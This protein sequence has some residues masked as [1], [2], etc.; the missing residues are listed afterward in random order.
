MKNIFHTLF[1]TL[2]LLGVTSC[3]EEQGKKLFSDIVKAPASSIERD[4]RGHEMIVSVQANLYYAR[5][6]SKNAFH[7]RRRINTFMGYNVAPFDTP[8]PTIQQ[9]EINKNDKGAMEITSQRKAFDVIKGENVYYVLELKYYDVNGKLINHQFSTYNKEDPDYSTLEQ[10]QTM[11]SVQTHSL[12]TQQLTYPMTLDSLYYDRYLFDMQ[13][14]KRVKASMSSSRAVYAPEQFQPNSLKYSDDLAIAAIDNT[15]TTKA[16]EP[17]TDPKTNEK[18]YLYRTLT[19][20]QLNELSKEIFSYEYRDT[21]PVDKPLFKKMLSDDQNRSRVSK[22][23]SF[24]RQRREL[25]IAV[26]VD[27]LGFKGLMQFK[28]ANMA[29]QLRVAICHII[30]AGSGCRPPS[31]GKY[32]ARQVAPFMPPLAQDIPTAWNT[33]DLDYPLPF[34]VIADLDENKEGFVEDIQRF[35]PEAKANDLQKMFASHLSDT[36][37]ERNETEADYF[38][39]I[40]FYHF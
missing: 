17:Y 30:D 22:P 20:D 38:R 9:I 39:R 24:L 36:P 21:D 4:V 13:G 12:N 11:F 31:C 15:M 29:F 28:H 37:G 26:P 6:S 33:Y 18:V 35:Y 32:I 3:T 19:G 16:I 10:H 27:Y 5:I 25:G 14:G 1:I 23:V 2:A 7:W 34:R 40:P 8:V